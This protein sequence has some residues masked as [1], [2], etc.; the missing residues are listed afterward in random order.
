[1]WLLILIVFLIRTARKWTEQWCFYV[2]TTKKYYSIRIS[3]PGVQVFSPGSVAGWQKRSFVL[4]LYTT[5]QWKHLS[6]SSILSALKV[7]PL[8]RSLQKAL[9]SRCADSWGRQREFPQWRPGEWP[10][11]PSGTCTLRICWFQRGHGCRSTLCQ[12]SA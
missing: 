5:E 12:R 6:H 4:R 3:R 8:G 9:K 11:T 1:M 10:G 2:I 7:E